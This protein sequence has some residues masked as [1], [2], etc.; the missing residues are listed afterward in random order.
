MVNLLYLMSRNN[1]FIYYFD[2]IV[3][4]GIMP[5][6]FLLSSMCVSHLIMPVFT[7]VSACVLVPC[8]ECQLFALYPSNLNLAARVSQCSQTCCPSHSV[9]GVKQVVRLLWGYQMSM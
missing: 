6:V 7:V 3:D 5:V 1:P 9:D 2:N 8:N 4:A